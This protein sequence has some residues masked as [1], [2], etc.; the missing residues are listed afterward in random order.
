MA[1]DRTKRENKKK[2]PLGS[3]CKT[4]VSP[5][6]TNKKITLKHFHFRSNFQRDGATYIAFCNRVLLETKLYWTADNWTAEDA[7]ILDQIIIVTKENDIRCEI[8]ER[9]GDLETLRR[10]SLKMESAAREVIEIDGEDI[11][12]MGTYSFKSLKNKRIQ[13]EHHQENK[14]HEEHH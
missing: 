2:H 12:K 1:Y 5:L 4:N 6:E 8:L 9:Y 11:Y 3:V 10:E 7:V 13:R 14:S